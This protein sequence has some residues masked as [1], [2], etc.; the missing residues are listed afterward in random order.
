MAVG[1]VIKGHLQIETVLTFV[2]PGL[3]ACQTLRDK[4]AKTLI[5]SHQN[6]CKKVNAMQR[7]QCKDAT[8]T[9]FSQYYGRNS[10]NGLH[11]I[12]STR[13]FS[14]F[15]FCA[16]IPR[17]VCFA[18]FLPCGDNRWEFSEAESWV[19]WIYPPALFLSQTHKR[20]INHMIALHCCSHQPFKNQKPTSFN[21]Q[22]EQCEAWVTGPQFHLCY[23]S[24]GID[25]L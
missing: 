4:T 17:N 23:I 8:Q 10:Y 2:G 25:F 14:F 16:T 6:F 13:L 24:G 12:I 11:W 18:I 9:Y 1:V 20:T 7:N 19:M 3:K 22:I 21:I 15:L 5:I